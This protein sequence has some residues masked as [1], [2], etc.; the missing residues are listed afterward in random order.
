MK[1][2]SNQKNARKQTWVRIKEYLKKRVSGIEMEEKYFSLHP[3]IY[4]YMS[5]LLWCFDEKQG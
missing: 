3:I 2:S 4:T 1:E 5:F